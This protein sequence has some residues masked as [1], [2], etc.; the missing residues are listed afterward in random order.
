[1][2]L[3]SWWGISGFAERLRA[4]QEGIF[5]VELGL[6]TKINLKWLVNIWGVGI[7]IGLI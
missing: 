2:G 1:L 6:E 7:W 3:V 5:S 4:S